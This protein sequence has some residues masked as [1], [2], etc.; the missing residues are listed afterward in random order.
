MVRVSRVR[1]RWRVRV[2]L[3]V[4]IRDRVNIVT[5]KSWLAPGMAISCLHF[6][7]MP[8]TFLVW[9]NLCDLVYP[10]VIRTY[11]T[12]TAVVTWL[13]YLHTKHSLLTH[14]ICYLCVGISNWRCR[15]VLRRP[16]T[17]AARWRT[18]PAEQVT[19]SEMPTCL[20]RRHLDRNCSR[21]DAPTAWDN[22]SHLSL[23]H[24]IIYHIISDGFITGGDAI[25][26]A[27]LSVSPSVFTLY[28]WNEWPLIL[29]FCMCIGH[30]HSSHGIEGRG[31][32]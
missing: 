9:N 5:C 2:S 18:L 16:D 28:F 23:C 8:L 6:Y 22:R 32:R 7:A 10:P 15:S 19:T 17:E 3:R 24:Y 13:P 4:K 21:L 14:R 11:L 26:A 12:V 31:H 25:T 29:T 30:D 27:R 1:V 20:R